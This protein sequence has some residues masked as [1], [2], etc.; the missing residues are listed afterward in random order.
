MAS[1]ETLRTQLDTMRLELQA[2]QVENWKLREE[3][4]EQNGLNKE[5]EL[6]QE[7][8]VVREENIGLTKELDKVTTLYQKER[9]SLEELEQLHQQVDEQGELVREQQ[10]A[11]AAAEKEIDQLSGSWCSSR[12]WLSLTDFMLWQLRQANGKPERGD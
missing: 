5:L 11:L 2:L 3:L 12:P 10:Q 4:Q 8:I 7:L 6:T 1:R 9:A